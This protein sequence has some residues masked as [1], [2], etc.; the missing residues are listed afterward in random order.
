MSN[1]RRVY[2]PAVLAQVSLV[3]CLGGWTSGCAGAVA[4][5]PWYA[6]R[7]ARFAMWTDTDPE[8]AREVI[9]DLERY[10]QILLA[11]TTAE[12]HD[13]APPL[14]I[15]LTRDAGSFAQLSGS[16]SANGLQTRGMFLATSRGNFA[17][18]DSREWS[19]V[20]D[21]EVSGR[22]LLFHEYAH[23]VLAM[24]GS[25]VPSW[26]NE[27]FAE[28]MST[29]TFDD[30]SIT[31]GCPPRYR[32]PFRSLAKWLPM[33][34]ILEADSVAALMRCETGFVRT[35]RPAV[36]SYL[37]SWYM[38]HYFASDAA[39][40]RQLHEYLQLWQQG[41]PVPVA[42][43]RAFGASIGEVGA[44]IE[45]YA[46]QPN[47]SCVLLEPGKPPAPPKIEVR[48]IS[49]EEARYRLADLMLAIQGPTDEVLALLQRDETGT[50]APSLR[51][52]ARAHLMRA[53]AGTGDVDRELT[54]AAILLDQVG[55]L[56]G[57]SAEGAS[58]TGDVERLRA[59]RLKATDHAAASAALQR[60]R[61]DY[62]KAIASDDG[63]AEAY[64][65][66][67]LT[68]AI[69]DT[70]SEEAVIAL[71]AAAYLLPL[72]VRPALEVGRLHIARGHKEKAVPALRFVVRWAHDAATRDAARRLLASLQS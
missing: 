58:L 13:A 27:G 65:G 41:V 67:G 32:M 5:H 61:A 62:R 50:Y 18:A 46:Q 40:K 9:G 33:Q 10:H 66:L 48:A 53:D 21:N 69:E 52:L 39:R 29:T 24:N 4:A 71:E 22:A 51:A 72:D 23:A 15:F 34:E 54:E 8:T 7:S 16:H 31:I 42:F 49:G 30:G 57:E 60:A 2:S 63:L 56:D 1:V 45:R 11:T 19:D 28:Y 64:L 43:E 14:R 68:Y 35:R 26:Y 37:Q 17:I 12:E 70:G 3:L 25:V 38:F 36:E 6:V 20:P 44:A 47:V 59:A 55:R